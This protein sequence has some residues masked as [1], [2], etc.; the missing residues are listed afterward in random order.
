MEV[1]SLAVFPYIEQFLEEDIITES[2][3]DKI[4]KQYLEVAELPQ[5][6]FISIN[7]NPLDNSS[8]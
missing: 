6:E 2:F 1:S 3:L 5:F 7:I 4:T 8:K